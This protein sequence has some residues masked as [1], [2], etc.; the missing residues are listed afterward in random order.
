MLDFA[1]Y[2]LVLGKADGK[3]SPAYI[4]MTS[5]SCTIQASYLTNAVR[6]ILV[7]AYWVGGKTAD[8]PTTTNGTITVKEKTT[9]GGDPNLCSLYAEITGFSTSNTMTV[10][11]SNL[12]SA[13]GLYL[14]II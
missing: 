10:T 14:I 4:K 3:A 13:V 9:T 7:G 12:Y 8:N 11:A 5:G 1:F 6:V 2:R